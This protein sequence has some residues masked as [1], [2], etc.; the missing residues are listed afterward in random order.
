M[1]LPCF[2]GDAE[3]GLARIGAPIEALA[4]DQWIVMHH[5]ERHDPTVRLVARRIVALMRAHR[6]AFAGRSAAGSSPSR[7]GGRSG[8]CGRRSRR[9]VAAGSRRRASASRES[10]RMIDRNWSMAV[11]SLGCP[12]ICVALRPPRQRAGAKAEFRK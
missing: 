12:G 11:A 8:A 1:L 3:P 5:D 9:G 10:K 7:D 2:V 6:A 4:S